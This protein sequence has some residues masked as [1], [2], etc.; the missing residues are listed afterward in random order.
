ME[1]K[2][3]LHFQKGQLDVGTMDITCTLIN[4][5]NLINM[6]K[7]NWHG[8]NSS[9]FVETLL[10]YRTDKKQIKESRKRIDKLFEW[11]KL[12]N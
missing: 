7:I 1:A 6:K 10:Y 8:I 9:V 4:D 12:V 2:T 3:R 11:P 5:I